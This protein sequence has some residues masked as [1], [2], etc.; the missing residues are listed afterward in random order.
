MSRSTLRRSLLVL[1][2]ATLS[3]GQAPH[4][5]ASEL[6]HAF[7][8]ASQSY[9]VPRPLLEGVGYVESNWWMHPGV[10]SI[11]HGYGIMDLTEGPNGSLTRAAKLTG[12]SE[13]ELKG[14]VESNVMGTAAL[15]R[16]IA[17][18]YFETYHNED[19]TKLADW[20]QVVMRYS[21]Y[22]D[23]QVADLFATEVYQEIRKG[24]R[25]AMPD[26]S[27]YFTGPLP[28]SVEGEKLFGSMPSALTPDYPS[29][30]WVAASSSNYTVANRPSQYAIN[31]VVIHTMQGSYA[32]SISWFQNPAA[33]A[34]AHYCVSKTGDITQMVQNKDVAWHAGNWTINTHSI[35]IE[36]EGYVTD[37]N[38]Y[39]DAMYK[40]SAALTKWLCDTYGIP[41][42]RQHIIGHYEVPDP[43]HPG[44]FGGSGHH[45]DP[46]I[47]LDGTQCYWNWSYYMQLVTGS[48]GPSTGTLEGFVFGNAGG[49]NQ[50]STTNAACKPLAG[51][52]VYIPETGAT[53]L[54]ASNGLWKFTL[55]PG[56]YTPS[57]SMAGYQDGHPWLGN[58][59]PV[60]AGNTTWGSFILQ[61]I[62]TTG[63][64]KGIVYAVNPANPS[65][66]SQTI[67]GAIVN[68][69]TN[70]TSASSA[71][72]YQL[73]GVAAGQ[74]S[75]HATADGF[76]DATV[77][78][79]VVAGQTATADIGLT[80]NTPP[81]N[82]PPV[83]A[84]THPANDSV[85]GFMPVDVEGTATDPDDT[86]STVKVNGQDVAVTSGKFTTSL[87]LA[88]G[89]QTVTAVA[90]DAAGNSGQAQLKIT[91][92]PNRPGV[93]GKVLDALTSK[94]VAS[95]VVT[96]GNTFYKTAADGVYQLDLP[97]GS[98]PVTVQA[99]GYQARSLTIDVLAD[100]RTNQDI[101]LVP[102]SAG[103]LISITS[104]KDNAVV[105][106]SKV[107]VSGTSH[108]P[109]LKSIT[110]NGVTATVNA[111]G[112][113]QAD[114]P[115]KEGKNAI[116]AVGTSQDG[117]EV[118]AGITV[119]YSPLAKVGSG[120]GCESG[121][122]VS[123]AALLGLLG[124]A[125]RRRRWRA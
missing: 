1:A 2:L 122:D 56:S 72:A 27:V 78:V 61:P 48:S 119:T 70:T 88:T 67:A 68:V 118:S 44:E 16:S 111:D 87:T 7:Q 40:A 9:D 124:L 43:N 58:A 104:P 81:D 105:T 121:F 107:V 17:D 14:D 39:T 28:V 41:K 114:V 25:V 65:D 57:A 63:S 92:D 96:S 22:A 12:F 45:T 5:D 47:T 3:C 36:H 83:V 35:G 85:V 62:A 51:A 37:P 64:V 80:K 42:D 34:S 75:V 123:F 53:Q 33:Q 59:R 11:D 50:P 6:D 69:G 13:A 98:A 112:T 106:T 89:E 108:L 49:C 20:W 100:Q 19:P 116:T 113:F 60:T 23:P 125:L 117:L 15:L 97:A 30:H 95:A 90:T 10:R 73:D 102:D 103:A 29:A 93:T 82:T 74:A 32:G 54:A 55:P 26:G 24:E 115:L 101:Y 8:R 71:G 46:C 38:A 84:F 21:G 99:A 4:D 91:Y 79:S 77:T 120:C 52:R 109:D 76:N 31:M 110:V 18:W 66:E 86:L 94:P